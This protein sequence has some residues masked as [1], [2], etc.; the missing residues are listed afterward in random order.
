M[1]KKKKKNVA[2]ILSIVYIVLNIVL[3]VKI[4]P[5]FGVLYKNS[6][7]AYMLPALK[8][9]LFGIFCFF[10]ALTCY[11]NVSKVIKDENDGMFGIAGVIFG[12]PT[13]IVYIIWNAGRQWLVKIFSQMML[14]FPT[15]EIL[16]IITED[17]KPFWE[18]HLLRIILKTVII[19]VLIFIA[20]WL[21]WIL[22]MIISN[23]LQFLALMGEDSEGASKERTRKNTN[24]DVNMGEIFEAVAEYEARKDL[25]RTAD[26]LENIH[27][28]LNRK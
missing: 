21:E 8:N 14:Y 27:Y 15:C 6:K 19:I 17:S 24:N 1:N 13:L 22:S 23:P 7:F 2:I 16:W 3:L 28:D 20:F 4:Y 9:V 26:A 25:K 10:F 12:V 5:E 11:E 18:Q